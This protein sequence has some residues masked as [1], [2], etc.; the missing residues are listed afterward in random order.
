MW[1]VV[2]PG[3][4]NLVLIKNSHR[5][6]WFKHS[7]WEKKKTFKQIYHKKILMFNHSK[8]FQYIFHLLS[9]EESDLRD[10]CAT[11]R[12]ELPV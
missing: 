3:K 6:V 9:N 2:R 12:S 8:R 10:Q 1:Q 7:M 4:K 5:I 11:D